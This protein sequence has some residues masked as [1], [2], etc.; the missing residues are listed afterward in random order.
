MQASGSLM[1]C[2]MCGYRLNNFSRSQIC[3]VCRYPLVNIG[4][5]ENDAYVILDNENQALKEELNNKNK[6]ID[7]L[8]KVIDKLVSE[9]EELIETINI[10]NS[11]VD[12]DPVN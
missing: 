1:G 4:L 8:I 11:P 12:E 2:A 3:I 9:K 5:I 10:L 7:S 6:Y